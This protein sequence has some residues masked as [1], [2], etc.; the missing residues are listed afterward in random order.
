MVNTVVERPH[1]AV[2]IADV[3]VTTPSQM[4]SE[5]HPPI[6][7]PEAPAV[8]PRGCTRLLNGT[9]YYVFMCLNADLPT[10]VLSSGTTLTPFFTLGMRTSLASLLLF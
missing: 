2:T 10:L 7:R 8:V 9:I 1:A 5:L 6:H 4:D 3:V